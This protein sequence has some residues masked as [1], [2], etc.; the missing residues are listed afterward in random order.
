LKGLSRTIFFATHNR[1]KFVEAAQ[2]TARFGIK[3]RHLR[4]EKKEIQSNDLREIACFAAEQAA[5]SKKCAVVSEDAGFFVNA[6]NGFPGPYSSYVFTTLGTGG[7]LRLLDGHRNR[8]AFFQAAVAFSRPRAPA[9][10]FTGVVNGHVS[11]KP[12]GTHGF[13]FDP[14][15]I[16][17]N[18]GGRTFAQMTSHEKNA[19]SH[20][21]VAFTKFSRWFIAKPAPI[22]P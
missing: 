8:E 9:E 20:R 6:L 22:R 15:F 2:I 3:L 13:G 11:K 16:P 14:I 19:L 4:I 12:S 17:R 18:G 10:C 5:E 7:I 1:G 21:A